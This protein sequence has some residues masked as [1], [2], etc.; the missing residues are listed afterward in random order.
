M[1]QQSDFPKNAILKKWGDK[2]VY[3]WVEIIVRYV[4][5]RITQFKAAKVQPSIRGMFYYL[6]DSQVVA[7]PNK[8]YKAFDSAL[9][10][11]RRKRPI[12]VGFIASGTFSDN[13]RRIIDI[14]D[15]YFSLDDKINGRIKRI[16][17][18]CYNFSKE[19]PIWLG[20]PNY[21][22]VWS[23]KAAMTGT[24]N[25]ILKDRQVRIAPNRGWSSIEFLHKNIERLEEQISKNKDFERI[26]DIW[27][28]YVGDFDPS[29]LKMDGHYERELRNKLEPKLGGH[30]HIHFKRIAL[31][32]LQITEFRLE[33]L[34]NA[35]L[36]GKDRK[37]L[38]KDPNAQWFKDKY[39][40]LFQI[41]VDS[42]QTLQ[43][44]KFKKLLTNEVDMLYSKHIRKDILA[45][46][47]HS[48]SPQ[49]IWNEIK[50]AWTHHQSIFDESFDKG[51]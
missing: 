8:F 31:T 45:R 13:T 42:L 39:G 18:L 22:E 21:V 51:D 34:K 44:T 33:H 15:K 36:S 25:S 6:T 40:S 30:V 11:A 12:D 28:L 19:I 38:E 49:E 48:K 50:K 5:P 27:I 17:D 16:I 26:K 32:W 4:I 1:A 37:K 24:L 47:D 41:Q 3:N 29:G 43:P 46:P 10:D 20:Q 7:K 23:E 35:I 14:D 2:S 9:A